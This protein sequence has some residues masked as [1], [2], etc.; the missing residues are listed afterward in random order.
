MHETCAPL[1]KL[2]SQHDPATGAVSY[3][4]HTD[5][6]R[7]PLCPA[8][9]K[10]L[11]LRYHHQ[12]ICP[13][14]KKQTKKAFLNGSCY[15]CFISAPETAPC[16]LHPEQCEAHLGKGRDPEWEQRHHHQPHTVYLSYTSHIKVGI[17]RSTQVPTRWIDQGAIAAIVLAKTPH[18]YAAGC[19]EVA[20]KQQL[21]DKTAWQRMLKHD[22]TLPLDLL[23]TKASLTPFIPADCQAYLT[24]QD[25]L[26]RLYYPIDR[27]PEKIRSL[28]LDKQPVIS[29]IL[30]G[31]KGQYLY[32][33]DDHVFNVRAHAGYVCTLTIFDA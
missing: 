13:Y 15:R 26:T 32:L 30:T 22:H 12:I 14:C 4:W 5:T 7:T 9:G 17:T 19:I 27:F 11:T 18:R 25:T 20:L 24:P 16:I 29:G 10:R 3:D 28:K 8:I 31:I 21:S 23:A 1:T 6:T 33:D 2:F